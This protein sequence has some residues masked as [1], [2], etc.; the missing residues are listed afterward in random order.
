MMVVIFML[1]RAEETFIYFLLRMVVIFM[2]PRAEE[3]YLLFAQV[4]I[5]VIF[6]L[7]RA[8]EMYL[9]FALD[10]CNFYATI[11]FKYL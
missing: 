3:M 1:P 9:I 4:R 2:L 8:E 11:C 5:V 10:G 6:M 7:P